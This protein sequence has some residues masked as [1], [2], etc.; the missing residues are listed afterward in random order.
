MRVSFWVSFYCSGKNE[1]EANLTAQRKKA[2]EN[3]IAAG[4]IWKEEVT[5]RLVDL[6]PLYGN[7]HGRNLP[8]RDAELLHQFIQRWATHPKL[9]RS[10]GEVPLGPGERPL[11]KVTLQH[12]TGLF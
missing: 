1:R 6:L 10:L 12:L 4:R 3:L 7:T 11:D 9:R 2:S 5:S 8:F